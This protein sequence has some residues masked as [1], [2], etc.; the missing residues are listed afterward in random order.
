MKITIWPNTFFFLNF[1][2]FTTSQ[3]Q[4][5]EQQVWAIRWSGRPDRT[6]RYLTRTLLILDHRVVRRNRRTTKVKMRTRL[7]CAALF[8]LG[9]AHYIF[10]P[11]RHT[12]TCAPRCLLMQ[13]SLLMSIWSKCRWV[14]AALAL[15]WSVHRSE[16]LEFFFPPFSW[17]RF[18][19][20]R[21]F[22]RFFFF[23]VWHFIAC[24]ICFLFSS[25]LFSFFIIGTGRELSC[26][27]TAGC[28]ET[29]HSRG[30]CA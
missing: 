26:W 4:P 2:I 6:E 1:T 11:H 3:H 5:G 21:R 29:A 14:D 25:R 20:Q 30:S 17:K 16:R 10:S 12:S 22:F 23:E 28:Q 15:S 13:N 27:R 8:F 24:W 19:R 9:G 18:F 7:V